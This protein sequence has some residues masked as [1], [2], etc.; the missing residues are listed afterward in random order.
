[1]D[2]YEAVLGVYLGS[3]G[4]A[5]KA[6]YERLG[7]I[8]PAGAIAVNLF[9]AQKSSGRAKVYRGGQRGR[10]SFRGMAYD[11]KGWALDNLCGGLVEHGEALG[12]AWGWGEDSKQPVH[13]HVLYV[14][15][16]AGQVSFHTGS[17]GVGPN[18][19]GRWDGVRGASPTR[20]CRWVADVLA[21]ET[22]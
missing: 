2:H 15:L 19:P 5:T 21:M 10:G 11:R 12:L 1:M 18:Y 7:A 22:A 4:E 20:V 17:R 8:G 16:P 9:R 13:R 6:L 3:D 14:D